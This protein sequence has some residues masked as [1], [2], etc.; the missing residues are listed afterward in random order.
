LNIL[1]T[2]GAGFIG[3]NF[4]RYV[5]RAYPDDSILNLDK[6]TYAGNL[7]NLAEVASHPSY[8]FVC[9]DI[10]DAAV[11]GDVLQRPFD[12]LVHF[13]AESHVDRSIADAQEFIRTNIQGTYTLL[14][15]ARRRG[16]SRFLHVSTDEVYGSMKPQQTADEGSPLRPNSPYA[17]SKASSDMLV[18]SYF[19]TH[20]FP[21]IITRSSNN[22]GPCQFPEKLIP[23]MITNAL[24]GKKLPVYG[25]GLNERDW[26]YVEDHCCALDHVLRSGRP[27]EVYNIGYGCP[28][29]NLEIVRQLLKILGKSEDLIEFVTDRPGHDRRY[30]LSISKIS[31]ELGWEPS[32]QLD[33]GLRRTVEWYEKNPDWVRKTRNGEYKTCYEDSSDQSRRTLAKL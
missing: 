9:G 2:G 19:K 7:A 22:Y 33:E 10:V 18:R 21:A 28:V 5:L 23:L 3:S 26:I 20:R 8:Q 6:L 25:D 1:V 14:E 12:A 24:E 27:G 32:V 15:A 17:A 16:V 30:A 4:I 11:V 29:R 13:A 31:G